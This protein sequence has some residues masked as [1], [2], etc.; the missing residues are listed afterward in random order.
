MSALATSRRHPIHPHS[1][2]LAFVSRILWHVA[3]SWQVHDGL[4]RTQLIQCLYEHRDLILDPS[5][6]EHADPN[7][8]VDKIARISRGETPP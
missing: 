5:R 3:L 8:Y 7:G 1:L 4:L 6:T 2:A